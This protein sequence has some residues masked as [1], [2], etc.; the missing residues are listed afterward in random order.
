MFFLKQQINEEG[1]GGGHAANA[2]G[3]TGLEHG[4]TAARAKPLYMGRQTGQ[5]MINNK[6]EPGFIQSSDLYSGSLCK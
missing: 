1:C 5:P 6:F 2:P 3:W 4:A